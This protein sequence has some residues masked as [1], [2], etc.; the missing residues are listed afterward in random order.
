[1]NCACDQASGV[2]EKVPSPRGKPGS[3]EGGNW[4]HTCS[5][6]IAPSLPAAA[7][8]ARRLEGEPEPASNSYSPRSPAKM[9]Q[10]R[11]IVVLLDQISVG[12][13]GKPMSQPE[14][15]F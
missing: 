1:M 2:A 11:P 3:P 10:M 6:S 8:A 9:G 5:G 14:P 13:A 15:S 7:I 12:F 4:S